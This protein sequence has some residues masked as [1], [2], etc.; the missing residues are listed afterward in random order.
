MGKPRILVTGGAGFIGSHLCESLLKEGSQVF[1]L[2]N[3][4]A[5]KQDNIRHLE[6]NSDFKFIKGDIR[7]INECSNQFNPIDYIFHDAAFVSVFDSVKNPI[8][9]NQINVEG[10]LQVLEYARQTDVK[11]LIFASSAAIYGD[12]PSLPKKE[13][14]FTI[15]SSPYGVSKQAAESYVIN[16]NELYDLETAALRYF[17]VFGPRQSDS[18]YSGVLSI[19]SKLILDNK[20]PTIFGDGYQTRD[21]IYVKDIVAGNLAAMKSKDAPGGIFNIGTGQPTKLIDITN[22]LLE[23]CNRKELQ[24]IFDEPRPGDVKESYADITRARKILGFEP[25]YSVK[26]G[27]MEYIKYKRSRER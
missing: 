7:E 3:L 18:G 4:S 11:R 24:I 20:P 12:D 1:C 14:Q 27:L 13:N 26:E 25:K 21:F 16:Y 10:T 5:G 2:D 15:P 23:I 17:N 9:C 19:F 6:E 22:D 8:L